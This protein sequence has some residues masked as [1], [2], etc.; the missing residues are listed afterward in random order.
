MQKDNCY[1]CKEDQHF[2]LYDFGSIQCNK[3][4]KI[5]TDN[6]IHL[7]LCTYRDGYLRDI[8]LCSEDCKK[9]YEEWVNELNKNYS[10]PSD[11]VCCVCGKPASLLLDY[12]EVDGHK[13]P[14][15]LYFCRDS[16]CL[17]S[18]DE[19]H[20]FLVL[21]GQHI[22]CSVCGT[23]TT[24]FVTIPKEGNQYNVC[25]R[26]ECISKALNPQFIPKF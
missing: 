8:F 4:G 23:D 3:C 18:F 11:A 10:I 20:D 26:K 12:V 14:N 16:A 25:N 19:H 5:I 24:N 1:A 7:S 15:K 2:F 22:I 6:P 13:A 9:K 17:D 21:N